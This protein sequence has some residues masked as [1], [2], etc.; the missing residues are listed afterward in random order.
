MRVIRGCALAVALGVMTSLGADGA[1][2]ASPV[3]VQRDGAFQIAGRTLRCGSLR[4]VLD[5]RLPSLGMMAPGVLVINPDLIA[6]H[7]ETVRLFVFHHECGHH[8]VGASELEADC[9][10]VR[11]GVRD[12]WLDRKGLGPVCDSFDDDPESPTHPRRIP[13]CANVERCFASATATLARRQQRPAATATSRS[14]SRP[15]VAAPKLVSGPA[16]IPRLVSG[17][18]LVRSG[19]LR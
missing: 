17:P 8:H 3:S 5:W 9:W 4:N 13:R 11:Q 6:D 2:S 19:T 15:A 16:R 1:L 12:G 14:Q 7:P 10:A 18:T